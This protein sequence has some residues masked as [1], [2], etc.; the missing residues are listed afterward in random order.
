MYWNT[1][2]PESRVFKLVEGVIFFNNIIELNVMAVF[3]SLWLY[4]EDF[5]KYVGDLNLIIV[6]HL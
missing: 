1:L 6:Q 2:D 3:L 5:Q 4:K